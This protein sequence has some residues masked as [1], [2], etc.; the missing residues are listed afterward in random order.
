VPLS[1]PTP[2]RSTPIATTVLPFVVCTGTDGKMSVTATFLRPSRDRRRSPAH[3]RA[4]GASSR[5][6]LRDGQG[7]GVAA[8]HVPDVQEV[9]TA[10]GTSLSAL[11]PEAPLPSW[12]EKLYP[13]DLTVPLFSSARL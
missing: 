2:R 10:T 13:Q 5:G 12:P 1:Q 11:L 9:L 4:R 3:H 7:E 6:L 8:V